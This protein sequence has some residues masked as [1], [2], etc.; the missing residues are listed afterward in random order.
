ML[1]MWLFFWDDAD[2]GP[3]VPPTPSTFWCAMTGMSALTSGAHVEEL[4]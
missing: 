3:Y 1:S 4:G 2:W